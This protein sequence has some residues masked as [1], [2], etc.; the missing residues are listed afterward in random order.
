MVVVVGL[1]LLAL[2]VLAGGFGEWLLFGL[3]LWGFFAI[4]RPGMR[5]RHHRQRVRGGWQPPSFWDQQ[6]S[7]WIAERAGRLPVD[8]QMKA[9]QISRKAESLMLYADRF[10]TGSQDLYVLQKTTSEYLPNTLDAYLALPPGYAHAAVSPD[11]KTALQA[12][13]EQLNLL[14]SKLDE[15]AYSLNRHNLDRLVAN[16]RFLEERFG[17]QESELDGVVVR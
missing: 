13:W 5:H 6:P 14:D 10:P 12:L 7:S 17:R 1:A 4:V 11:G 3:F 9:E 8:V 2:V 15:I 16:G